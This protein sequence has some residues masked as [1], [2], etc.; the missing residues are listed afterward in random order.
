MRISAEYPSITLGRY[1]PEGYMCLLSD[2]QALRGWLSW[3][4]SLRAQ[5]GTLLPLLTLAGEL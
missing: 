3:L 2:M 4:P 1:S 5:K